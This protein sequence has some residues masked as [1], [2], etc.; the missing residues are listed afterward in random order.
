MGHGERILRLGQQSGIDPL[1]I[2]QWQLESGMAT[3]GANS[4]GNGGNM[5][6]AAARPYADEYGCA[7]G[8]SFG[9]ARWA[10]CPTVEGG[11][12][13]WFRYVGDFYPPRATDLAGYARIY[14]PCSDPG[15]IALMLPCGDRYAQLL[16][17][18]VRDYA[19][20][21]LNPPPPSAPGLPLPPRTGCGAFLP[22]R[23]ALVNLGLPTGVTEIAAIVLGGKT[24]PVTQGWGPSPLRGEP[25]WLG[26][27]H[28]HTGVDLATPMHT[29]IYAPV[30]GTAE[31]QTNGGGFTEAV[32]MANG[33]TWHFFHLD[34]QVAR[35]PVVRGQLIGFSGNT[36]Y[37]TGPHLHIELRDAQGKYVAPEHWVCHLP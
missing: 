10:S 8:N 35:G 4:P 7:A 28:F 3:V 14:N 2:A 21:P 25:A 32:Q 12:G 13:I 27:P 30:E 18:L 11:L 33:A 34:R 6:W 19:G 37:S 1:L 17:G 15:N 29:P 26:Y 31:P 22:I 9:G 24:F 20:P 5:I 23:D 36:G 16:V